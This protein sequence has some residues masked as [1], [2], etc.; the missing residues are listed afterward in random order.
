MQYFLLVV[1]VVVIIK[2]YAVASIMDVNHSD[3]VVLPVPL[4]IVL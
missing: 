4:V 2:L 3:V 1:L